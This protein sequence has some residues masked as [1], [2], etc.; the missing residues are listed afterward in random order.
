MRRGLS[1]GEYLSGLLD[2]LVN[3]DYQ[4]VLKELASEERGG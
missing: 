2:S 3:R 4:P 1:I